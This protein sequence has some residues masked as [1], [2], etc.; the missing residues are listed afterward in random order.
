MTDA[1]FNSNLNMVII[2]NSLLVILLIGKFNRNQLCYMFW[3]EMIYVQSENQMKN[4]IE[5]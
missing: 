3:H 2:W 5:N 1:T 4:N